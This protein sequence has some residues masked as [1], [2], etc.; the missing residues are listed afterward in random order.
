MKVELVLAVFLLA[1]CVEPSRDEA[2]TGHCVDEAPPSPVATFLPRFADDGDA[3]ARRL[4]LA[5]QE[6][7]LDDPWTAV[8]P[9]DGEFWMGERRYMVG[10]DRQLVYEGSNRLSQAQMEQILATYYRLWEVLEK[11]RPI[12]A[13][14]NGTV[15]IIIEA[16]QPAPYG[17]GAV[18]FES[19]KDP[20]DTKGSI[21]IAWPLYDLA[22][23]PWPV[24]PPQAQATAETALRCLADSA[25][26]PVP[27]ESFNGDAEPPTAPTALHEGHA[28]Y[29]FSFA[30]AK[31][32]GQCTWAGVDV[33][34]ITGAVLQARANASS[35]CAY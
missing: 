4:R 33:D 3:Q 9:P 25:Q 1:G 20:L 2:P 15:R 23:D 30:T 28:V 35:Y 14:H 22:T 26:P 18:T 17:T 8:D 6:T 24:T 12:G 10:A 34:A 16:R 21:F 11:D 27:R 29:V 5:M 19:S 32:D 13:P 7:P 31:Q